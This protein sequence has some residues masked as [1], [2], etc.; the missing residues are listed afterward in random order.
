MKHEQQG[1]GLSFLRRFGRGTAIDQ[2]RRA[3]CGDCGEVYP[4]DERGRTR[5]AKRGYGS[6]LL[7]LGL[8]GLL[9]LCVVAA[10]IAAVVLSKRDANVPAA[11]VAAADLKKIEIFMT[12]AQVEGILGQGE[13]AD[14][15]DIDPAW[16]QAGQQ[17]RATLWLIWRNGGDYLVVGF[18][19]GGT[20]THRAVISFFVHNFN[21]PGAFGQ[22]TTKGF[23]NLDFPGTDLDD[24]AKEKA[25]AKA[26]L[27]APRWLKGADIRKSLVGDWVAVFIGSYEFKQDGTCSGGSP[28][29]KF[30]G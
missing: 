12:R 25:K 7:W 9:L 2:G 19:Q 26:L 20:G 1:P 16:W 3:R 24:S 15:R 6:L 10:I 23:I 11:Q 22:E 30:T 4:V 13:E 17:C 5:A 28:G 14:A 8:G 21:Q 18:G 29:G 27:Q